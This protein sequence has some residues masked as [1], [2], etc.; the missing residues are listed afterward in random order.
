LERLD[1]EKAAWE[2]WSR[3]VEQIFDRVGQSLTDA[4]FDGGKSAKDLLRDLFKGLTFNVLINPI[5]NQMQGWV[6]NQ[7][8]GLFGAQNPQQG[9]MLGT[10]QNL[11]SGYNAITGGL[12]STLGNAAQWL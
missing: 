4:I 12:N 1:A 8:G 10:A 11:Y 3:D 2:T 6:T 9:G 7:L 5:M